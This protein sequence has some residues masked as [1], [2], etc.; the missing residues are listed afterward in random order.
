MINLAP[1]EFPDFLAN[2]FTLRRYRGLL[3]GSAV[4]V[5]ALSSAV[6]ALAACD[7]PVATGGVTVIQCSGTIT[8][9]DSAA[10]TYSSATQPFEI[11]STATVS[12]T[13]ANATGIFGVGSGPYVLVN[14]S[15]SIRT[16]G[17]SSVGIVALG[18]NGIGIAQFNGTI[19]T[20]GSYSA[21]I[22]AAS[23]SQ[24]FGNAGIYS[25]GSVTT[26]GMGAHG[27]HSVT[28]ADNSGL[29]P[30]T[31][32][33][34]RI[35][36]ESNIVTRGNDARG[37]L[38]DN[39]INGTSGDGD[40]TVT[41]KGTVSTYGDNAEGI[42]VVNRTTGAT[43]VA[44]SGAIS[45][46]GW[47]SHGISV[48]DNATSGNGTV[49]VKSSGP[50]TTRGGNADGIRATSAGTGTIGIDVSGS[51]ATSAASSVGVR[52]TSGGNVNISLAS[53]GKITSAQTA[54]DASGSSVAIRSSGQI[55]GSIL[56]NG[57]SSSLTNDKYG[58]MNSGSDIALG[59]S[60][61]F[62]NA[63][64]LSPGG[65]GALRTTTLTGSYVQTGTARMMVDASWRTGMADNLAVSGSAA[66][67]GT[68]VVN[69]IDLGSKQGLTRSF[70]VV[71]AAGGVV[72]N[73]LI[74]ASTGAATYSIAKPDANTLALKAAVDFRGNPA[75]GLTDNQKAVGTA[76]N[77]IFSAGT[78]LPFM[79]SLLTI[80]SASYARAISQLMPT[81]ESASVSGALQTG[82]TFASHLLSCRELGDSGDAYRFIRED[83]C[84]WVR[85]GGRRLVGDG[86]RDGIGFAENSS[87]LSAGMQLKMQGDWRIG[88]GV[89]Y[90]QSDLSTKTQA[91]MQTERLHLG[92]V[93]KYVPGPWIFAATI[94]GGLG[95]HDSVRRI[96]FGDYS[97]VARSDPESSFIAGRLTAAHVFGFGSWY[98]KPQV[99]MSATQ[100][101]R[102]A[103][104]ETSNGGAALRVAQRDNTVL[105][106]SPMLE[107]GAEHQFAGA[108]YRAFVR[109]GA[110]FR[111]TNVYVTT[112]SFADTSTVT[113]PFSIASRVDR[114][115]GDVGAGIDALLSRGTTIR[116]QYDGQFGETTTHHSGAAKLGVKF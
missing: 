58:T 91:T 112:A 10:I 88:A 5:T 42:L 14:S 33:M 71:S 66:V 76:L 2:R 15:G 61:V 103:F 1:S 67:G 72:D 79:P 95:H 50:I 56:A 74:V 73:G 38:A 65:S 19:Q 48:N 53:G 22:Y 78:S 100:F 90:E 87:L 32:G 80:D 47:G 52:A 82:S 3:L 63:G 106:A 93:I 64:T 17:D 28:E 4:S 13:G 30:A 18:Y 40:V 114:I 6:P 39:F 24:T 60:G 43:T 7:N 104:T 92:G 21:G 55:D 8:A 113:A 107:I 70:T 83:Q 89:G 108:T 59:S 11:L 34:I 12:T 69:P 29:T 57:S 54:I 81:A 49:S 75:T 109:G 20:A 35:I 105:S 36:A 27:L 25:I 68:I 94:N 23:V 101:S 44:S 51:I 85:L 62:T 97:T 31:G 96:S 110:T 46:Y 77:Q 98:L 84:A 86:S 102:D 37:I 9:K 115:T 99:E 45:T 41:L 111:D 26:T 16:T 116:F